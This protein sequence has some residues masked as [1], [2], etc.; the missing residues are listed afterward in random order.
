MVYLYT[1]FISTII[2]ADLNTQQ[3]VNRGEIVF[4]VKIINSFFPFSI[5]PPCPP[6]KD[7]VF[8]FLCKCAPR[9][10][11]NGGHLCSVWIGK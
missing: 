4:S 7:I 5:L 9:M 2:P 3:L 6:Q 1:V 10:L 11:F 8:L